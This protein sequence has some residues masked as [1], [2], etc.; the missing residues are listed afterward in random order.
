M[1]RSLVFVAA[2]LVVEVKQ[3][4][5]LG[6]R[7]SE[8]NNIASAARDIAVIDGDG[9]E[10]CELF[11]LRHHGLQARSLNAYRDAVLFSRINRSI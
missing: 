10:H 1:R 9:D 3:T 11:T 7:E 4:Q 8:A 5:R 2:S 6:A